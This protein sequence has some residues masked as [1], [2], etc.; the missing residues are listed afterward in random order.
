MPS[1]TASV[2]RSWPPEKATLLKYWLSGMLTTFLA[3]TA[4]GIS[5][6]EVLAG[7]TSSITEPFNESMVVNFD[8]FL[9]ISSDL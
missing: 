3:N 7:S 6:P 8:P 5:A 4:S 1:A 2:D 9:V